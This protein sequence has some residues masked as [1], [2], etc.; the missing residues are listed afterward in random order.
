MHMAIQMMKYYVCVALY[1]LLSVC[2]GASKASR[3][4][5]GLLFMSVCS[6]LA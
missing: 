1:L 3:Y 2:V 5:Y 4:N 6:P